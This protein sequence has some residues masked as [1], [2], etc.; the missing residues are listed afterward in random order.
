METTLKAVF[1]F[2]A[3]PWLSQR[4]AELSGELVAF[5][6]VDERDDRKFMREMADA[7]VLCHVLKP[8]TAEI[9]RDAPGLRLIQKIGV[10]VNTIDLDAA[11]QNDIAVCNMP[12]T[13]SAA[14]AELTLG[15]MLAVLRKLTLFDRR[16]R[17]DE[18]W[19]IPPHWQGELG[20]IGS[21]RV[22]L[23]GSGAVPRK[24]APILESFGAEVV[25]TSRR[26]AADFPYPFLDKSS[27][28]ASS[29]IVSLHIP[30]TPQ[31]LG[32]LDRQAILQMKPGAI[33][34]NTARGGLVDQEAL[35][36]ALGDGSLA[37]AGLDV[38]AQEPV[39]PGTDL[40]AFENVVALPHAAWATRETLERSLHVVM[41]NCRRLAAGEELLHRVV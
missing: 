15:L 28:L 27:L 38:F 37:G 7:E 5:V 8:I 24:L 18:G 30:E 1:H 10:G 36:A 31:T 11:K 29:D 40:L 19:P 41:E 22:G 20:E 6:A 12:G 2:D 33:L 17:T 26:Q 13:N 23:V 32:Y 3:G 9:L 14:V 16:I 25:Y 35:V 4:L 34:I 39:D 21:R